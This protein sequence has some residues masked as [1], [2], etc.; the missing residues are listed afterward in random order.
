MFHPFV[1]VS[2]IIVA[3]DRRVI[4][5]RVKLNEIRVLIPRLFGEDCKILRHA[6][7][8]KFKQLK[9]IVTAMDYFD[10]RASP[11]YNAKLVRRGKFYLDLSCVKNWGWELREMYVFSSI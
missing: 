11:E 9:Y 1:E 3:D 10:T 8:Y 2:I 7:P 5:L 4:S 6:V